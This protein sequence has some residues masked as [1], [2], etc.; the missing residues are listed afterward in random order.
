MRSASPRVETSAQRACI[1]WHVTRG[2]LRVAVHRYDLALARATLS[3]LSPAAAE[4]LALALETLRTFALEAPWAFLPAPGAAGAAGAA[5][6]A[7]ARAAVG[8]GGGAGRALS[9]AVAET[10]ASVAALVVDG[11]VLPALATAARLVA[12]PVGG[13]APGGALA[14]SDDPAAAGNKLARVPF[15]PTLN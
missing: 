2:C 3:R 13:Q 8:A 1:G 7:G 12:A 5:G 14:A 10:Y 15:P 11:L 9:E 6:G 4:A